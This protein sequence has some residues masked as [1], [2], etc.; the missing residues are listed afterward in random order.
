MLVLV[1]TVVY[2]CSGNKVQRNDMKQ[3]FEMDSSILPNG[4]TWV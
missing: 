2:T 3:A 1:S 4:D